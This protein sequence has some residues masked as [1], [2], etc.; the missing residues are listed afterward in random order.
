MQY[1]AKILYTTDTLNGSILK[2]IMNRDI[3]F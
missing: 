3:P 1:G 2:K